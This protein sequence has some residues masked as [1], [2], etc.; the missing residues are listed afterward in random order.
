[1]VA[2]TIKTTSLKPYDIVCE[3]KDIHDVF[4]LLED[5]SQVLQFKLTLPSSGVMTKSDFAYHGYDGY[6]KL[7]GKFDW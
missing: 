1:M 7:V 2:I 3:H 4:S 5:S 6:S